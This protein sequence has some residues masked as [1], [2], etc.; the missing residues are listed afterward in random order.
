MPIGRRL[1][2]PSPW[3]MLTRVRSGTP[4]SKTQAIDRQLSRQGAAPCT[5]DN[6]GTAYVR[7]TTKGIPDGHAEDLLSPV[8]HRG[9]VP[10]GQRGIGQLEIA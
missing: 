2:T 6:S 10:T 8:L 9:E 3:N 5:T 1:A 7:D 4:A